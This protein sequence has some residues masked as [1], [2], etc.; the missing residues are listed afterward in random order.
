[1]AQTLEELK[2]KL[3]ELEKLRLELYGKEEISKIEKELKKENKEKEIE[4]E[5]V[6]EQPKD[7][8]DKLAKKGFIF[9]IISILLP[10]ISFIALESLTK[11]L[12]KKDLTKKKMAVAGLIISI[13]TALVFVGL[14]ALMYIKPE[15]FGKFMSNFN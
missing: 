9:A 6:E 2:T 3:A 15:I 10:F 1:M 11:C 13:I 4:K 14:M 12:K 5:K 7:N 8:A